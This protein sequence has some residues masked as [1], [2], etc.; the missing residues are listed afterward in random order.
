LW[1]GWHK[2]NPKSIRQLSLKPGEEKIKKGLEAVLEM[3]DPSQSQRDMILWELTDH[4]KM[5]KSDL[6]RRSGL[7]LGRTNQDR[8]QIDCINNILSLYFNF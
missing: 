7:R 4:G 5:K 3:T 1:L 2:R 8:H 6:R